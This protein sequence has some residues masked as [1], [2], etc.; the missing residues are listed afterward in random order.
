MEKETSSRIGLGSP[1]AEPFEKGRSGSPK[2][3]LH[4]ASH[5]E[6]GCGPLTSPA[7]P[8][9]L[10]P[11]FPPSLLPKRESISKFPVGAVSF[12]KTR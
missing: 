11:P 9:L 1:Q 10:P 3:R 4:G 5:G 2:P 7:V 12:D 8:S 6:L